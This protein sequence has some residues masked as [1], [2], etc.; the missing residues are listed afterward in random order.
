MY[1]KGYTC[2]CRN[3]HYLYKCPLPIEMS[4]IYRNAYY[5]YK[6]HKLCYTIGV[7]IINVWEHTRLVLTFTNQF[8]I[9]IK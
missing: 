1:V 6:I 5:L 3:T 9:I 7:V 2:L 8:V 4:A